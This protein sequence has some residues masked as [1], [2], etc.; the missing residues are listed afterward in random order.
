MVE[1]IVCFKLKP[2]TTQEQGQKLIDMLNGL[3]GKV[4]T[5]VSL[6]AGWNFTPERGQGF[7]I[8]LVVRFQDKEGLAVYQP[9]PDHALVKQYVGQICESSLVVD[10][11]F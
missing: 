2:E 10:Y 6:T 5:I 7:M 4:P 11:E 8:G 9:H 3:K 1:H